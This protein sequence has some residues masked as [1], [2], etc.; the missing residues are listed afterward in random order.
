MNWY[1]AG[2]LASIVMPTRIPPR[3]GMAGTWL[4]RRIVTFPL[5]DGSSVTCRLQDAGDIVSIYIDEDYGPFPIPWRSV[6]TII[7]VGATTGCFTLWAHQRA[8]GAHVLAIEPNP[9]V[10]PFL[11]RNTASLDVQPVQL[12]LGAVAGYGEVSDQSFST[13]ATVTPSTSTTGVRMATLEEAMDEAKIGRCDLLKIDIEGGEFDVLLTAPSRVFNRIRMIVCEF[14]PIPARS[15]D[16]LVRR[17]TEVS[18]Q[19]SVSGGPIGFIFARRQ[20]DQ[21]PSL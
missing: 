13:L 15:V 9:A 19:V 3:R 14:H 7:D 20:E 18:F 1:G 5:R 2:I 17:L 6:Q 8:P 10:Y 12:A 11:V 16:E 21:P 4:G